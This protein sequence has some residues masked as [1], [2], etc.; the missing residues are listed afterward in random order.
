MSATYPTQKCQHGKFG[1]MSG[2]RGACSR[3]SP[4]EPVRALVSYPESSQATREGYDVVSPETY[5]HGGGGHSNKKNSSRSQRKHVQ[6]PVAR[7]R[8]RERP[9]TL[10][11]SSAAEGGDNDSGSR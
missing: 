3:K 10:V 8:A 1:N 9:G 11:L 7:T 6:G 5:L 4:T 2:G